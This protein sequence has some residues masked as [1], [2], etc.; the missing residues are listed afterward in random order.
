MEINVTTRIPFSIQKV[1]LAMQDHLPELA[2]F[3]PNI[4]SITVEKKEKLDDDWLLLVNR[5]KTAPTEIP[6]VAKPFIDQD[7]TH[8]L[9]YAKWNPKTHFCNWRLEMGFMPDRI[10]CS[11]STSYHSIDANQT[12]MRINGSLEINLKGLVPRLLLRRASSGVEKFIA[13]LVQPNFQKT[14]DALTAYLRSEEQ[15]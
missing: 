3:M 6:A 7:K 15:K 5:W 9:D 2:E 4:E 1:Y 8:W 11:G 12:E 13:R 10:K 14:A